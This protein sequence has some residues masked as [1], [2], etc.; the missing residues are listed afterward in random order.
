[1]TYIINL[2]GS[3]GS[4]KSTL[5]ALLFGEMKKQGFSVD[6]VTEYAKELVWEERNATFDDELYIF[7]KQNH[8]LFR[9]NNK[10]DFIVTDA[11]LLQKLYY[12]PVEFDFSDL[13]ID[14]YNQYKNIN[15]FLERKWWDFESNGRKQTEEE[16]NNIKESMLSKLN[17]YNINYE[18]INSKSSTDEDIVR[19]LHLIK[20]LDNTD[21]NK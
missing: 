15:F 8:R 20:N 5:A 16:S 4:G 12:M 21:L 1:M 10:V 6:L 14:V 18:F 13:V 3:P 9:L 17:N 19:I 7:A 2:I 11:P